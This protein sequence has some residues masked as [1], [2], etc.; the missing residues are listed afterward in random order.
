MIAYFTRHILLLP[1]LQS[2][3]LSL[4]EAASIDGASG[5]QSFRYIT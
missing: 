1:G 4:Y 2:I 3:S 5:R